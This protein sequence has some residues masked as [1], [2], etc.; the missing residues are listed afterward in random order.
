MDH[1]ENVRLDDAVTEI[2]PSLG[3]SDFQF[4]ISD[5]CFK[6]E[7]D[8]RIKSGHELFSKQLHSHTIEI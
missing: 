1:G 7:S 4:C 6:G 2:H 8:A 3:N 5:L